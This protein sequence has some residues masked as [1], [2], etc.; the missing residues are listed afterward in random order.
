MEATEGEGG[1]MRDPRIDPAPAIDA[2]RE[3]KG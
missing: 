3:A 1:K 2:A